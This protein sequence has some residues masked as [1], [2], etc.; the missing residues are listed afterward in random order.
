[1][2][3]KVIYLFVA[4]HCVTWPSL[5]VALTATEKQA[6]LDA[7]N[8]ARS[9]VSPTA[10]NMQMMQW[11]D[12]IAAFA[13]EYAERCAFDH[14]TSGERSSSTGGGKRLL[15]PECC[16]R[17]LATPGTTSPTTTSINTALTTTVITMVTS[18]DGMLAVVLGG[19]VLV[20]VA[21]SERLGTT[22]VLVLV[23]ASIGMS[24]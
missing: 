20:D 23:E 11:D 9:A 7:H 4:A 17:I 12:S 10:S 6:L 18:C 16:I 21:V 2:L 22:G 19:G 13:Q 5:A 3:A 14:S 1:M 24:G 15:Y 8:A